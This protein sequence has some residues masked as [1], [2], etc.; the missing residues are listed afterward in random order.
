MSARVLEVAPDE[1]RDDPC[2]SPSL[3]HSIAHALVTLSPRHAWLEHPRLGG[4]QRRQS[5]AAMDEG[6]IL[7]RLVL[8]KGA[9]FELVNA[10]DYRQGWARELRDEIRAAGRV[11][12]L[13]REFEALSRLADHIRRRCA[14]E[15]F[16]LAGRAELAIEFTQDGERAP[17][18]CRAMLDLVRAD[19]VLLDLK[20][21]ANANPRELGRKIYDM[22]YDIQAAAYSAAY[23]QLEPE[24]LGRSDFVFLFCEA[25]APH[26]VVP[27]RL[28]GALREIGARRWA[29]AVRAWERLLTDGSF[30][31]PGYSDGALTVSAPAWALAEELGS[32]YL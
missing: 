30:P 25:E 15:G 9:Q 26:E 20:R 18:L 3:S 31:W 12:I 1:Y 29:R 5:T 13:T 7:H 21:V 8:G 17:V 27:V 14:Q 6:S 23:E 28:D 24:A 10:P 22:G 11:P 4:A 32:D 2:A 19:H 16:E